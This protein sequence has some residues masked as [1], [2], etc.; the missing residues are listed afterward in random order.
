M[1]VSVRSRALASSRY[2]ARSSMYSRWAAPRIDLFDEEIE[3]IRRFD[4]ESQRS[5]DALDSVRL[6]PAREMPLDAEAVKEFRRRFRTRF[7]GDP[8]RTTIYRGVSEG[9]APA[10]IE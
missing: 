7:E 9:L 10:G 3:A 1:R 5:L 4:P 2:A 8:N 6:L